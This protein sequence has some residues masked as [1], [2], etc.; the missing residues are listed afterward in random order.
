MGKKDCARRRRAKCEALSAQK[1]RC[2]YCKS[3]LGEGRA[4]ADHRMA[5]TKGGADCREN[6]AAACYPCNQVKADLP[7]SYFFKLITGKNPP[8]R[9]GLDMMMIWSSRRIWKRAYRACDR[10]IQAS[11]FVPHRVPASQTEIANDRAGA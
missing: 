10:L 11:V 3:P 5:R 7:E 9:G 8:R 2:F 1:G 6:I 4:T